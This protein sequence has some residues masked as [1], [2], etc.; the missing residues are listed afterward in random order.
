MLHFAVVQVSALFLFK[1]VLKAF[2]LVNVEG[3]KS[4]EF[5]SSDERH[6]LCRIHTCMSVGNT[7]REKNI[8]FYFIGCV[9]WH[10]TNS[11]SP[12]ARLDS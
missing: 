1:Q 7:R 9:L 6:F 2:E 11:T 4:D 8:I 3:L 12:A 5:F 10:K